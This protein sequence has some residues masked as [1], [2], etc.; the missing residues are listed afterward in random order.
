MLERKKM[1]AS[2][3]LLQHRLLLCLSVVLAHLDEVDVKVAD[4]AHVSEGSHYILHQ[5]A[6]PAPQL[7][8]PESVERGST[9]WIH[10]LSLLEEV[11]DPHTNHFAKE[12]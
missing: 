9:F 7:D 3:K 11:G 8:K 5:Q 12:G 2:L 10:G 1:V 6:S 4:D